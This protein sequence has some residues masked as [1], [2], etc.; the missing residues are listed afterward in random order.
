ME[1]ETY[2]EGT[3]VVT[4]AVCA[5]PY[6]LGSIDA[7]STTLTI[8]DAGTFVVGD[9][10]VVKGAGYEGGDLFA[11]V[12]AV[13]GHTITL[14]TPAGASAHRA[15][16][17]KLANPGSVTFTAR[18]AD[19]APVEYDD[20]DVEVTSPTV[21]VWELRVV[22]DEDDWVVHFQGTTPCHCAGETSFRVK[23]S[24]ALA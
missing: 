15:G 18:R 7:G 2:V 8:R 22:H 14:D 11:E 20:G 21:G 12:D 10:I 4:R 19:A 13:N 16:A 9:D 3:Q 1:L 5:T 6:T 23:R 24:R 17:G